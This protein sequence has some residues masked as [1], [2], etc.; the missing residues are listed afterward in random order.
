MAVSGVLGKRNLDRLEVRLELAEELYDGLPTL[1]GVTLKNG[2][3]RLPACL[4]E[5]LLNDGE[6][7][8]LFPIL[9]ARQGDTGQVAMT[10]RG[11]GN[12]PLPGITV[13]SI[14]PINFFR[15]YKTLPPQ[16]QMT[17]FPAPRKCPPPLSPG[18]K[19]RH[20]EQESGIRGSEGDV[21]RIHDY[22]EGDPLKLIHW[23][24]SAKHDTFKV[25]DL[26]AT[27][28][29]P[30]WV[31]PAHC[32]GGNL[33]ERLRCAVYLVNHGWKEGRPVGLRLPERQVPPATGRGHR[34]HLLHLLAGYGKH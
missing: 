28:R 22:R 2:R 3:G 19:T 30:L 18:G 17:V 16:G 33:E 15:R 26:A 24:L 25:K 8:V 1:V 34:L 10:F 31:D 20:G 27:T 32:P 23:K 7:R 14:F 6:A 21:E 4:I 9:P 12:R 5:V 29:D 13:R 11:R